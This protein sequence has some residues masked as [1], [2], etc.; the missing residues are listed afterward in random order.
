MGI[1]LCYIAFFSL[2]AFL[3]PFVW[4][5]RKFKNPYRLIFVIGGKGSGKTTTI[6]KESFRALKKGKPVYTTETVPGTV[7]FNVDCVGKNAFPENA[8]VFIDEA[9]MKYD[10]RD[11]KSFPKE[12]RNYFKYQRHEKNTVWMFS[13]SF[14]V[15]K[16]IRDLADEIYLMTCH[17]NII[18]VARRFKKTF[19]IVEATSAGESRLAENY[20]FE[21]LWLALFGVKVIMITFIP[22]WAHLFN[23]HDKLGLP[24]VPDPQFTPVPDS[25]AQMY[26]FLDPDKK[27]PNFF[28]RLKFFY[29]SV[30]ARQMSGKQI[31]ALI[32]VVDDVPDDDVPDDDFDIFDI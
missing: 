1:L 8:V 27:K 7:K 16:K 12:V 28:Q 13:Q 14:D 21:P 10:S 11:F 6:A 5:S 24:D 9:G 2:I 23:S 17:F 19:K 3:I 30:F 32:D 29:D 4:L 20:E 31:K 26:Y 25:A 15:D 18:S 22:R